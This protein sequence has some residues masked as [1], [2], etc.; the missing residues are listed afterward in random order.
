MAA[1]NQGRFPKSSPGTPQFERAISDI[2]RIGSMEAG[3]NGHGAP[4][5]ALEVRNQA[6]GFLRRLLSNFGTSI[7]APTLIAP[8]SDGGVT[9]EWRLR[10]PSEAIEFVFLPNGSHEYSFR[11]LDKDR[12]DR[13]EE[14]VPEGELFRWAK[15]ALVGRTTV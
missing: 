13:V 1:M 6:I 2:E 14:D 15:I 3:W 5:A 11:D 4:I 10:E 7:P 8:T 9:L 12:L